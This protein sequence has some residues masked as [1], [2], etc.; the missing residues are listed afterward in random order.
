MRHHQQPDIYESGKCC[1]AWALLHFLIACLLAASLFQCRQ[2]DQAEAGA[3]PIPNDWFYRQRA[4]PSGQI[5]QAKYVKAM[6]QQQA[7][8]AAFAMRGLSSQ[9]VFRGPTNI[10][11]RIADLAIHPANPNT[12]FVGAASGG[13]FRSYDRGNTF[14]PIFD[15]ALSLSIGDIEIAPSNPAVIYAGTGEANAGGGS[16]A[17]EGV[18]I[19]KS[20]NG[21]NTWQHSGLENSGSIGRIAIHPANPNR[22]YAAA[23]GRL[24]GNNAERGVYRSSNGGQ[25]WEQVLFLNDSTGAID[26]A[27]HPNRPDTLYAAMW[28]RL[29]RP[30]YYYYGGYSSGIYRSY[31]GGD[32]WEKLANG[33]PQG[34]AGRI[35]LALSPANPQVIY[36]QYITPI[37]HIMGVYR[38]NDGGNSW[39]STGTSGITGPNFMWWFGR[40]FPHPHDPETVYFP[41]I[42]LFR[43][44]NGGQNWVGV[45]SGVHVDQHDLY[46]DPNNPDYLVLANDGGLYISENSAQSWEH[47]KGLPLIQ[48]YTCEVDYS[49][50]QRRYGG[51]Q[52]NGTIRTTTG[53]TND[54]R[55]ILPGDGFYCLVDPTDNNFV[56][57]ESQYGI[58][59]RSINGG[60]SFQFALAG[61]PSTDRRNWNTPFVFNP[62]NPRSLYYGTFRL[63]KS[64]NRALSWSAISDNLTGPGEPG[65]L[66]YGTITSIS[67]SAVDTNLIYVATDNGL[68]WKT[69]DGGQ[70]WQLLSSALPRRW[71]TRV[72]AC[73]ADALT[74][75]VTF[76]GY[77]FD[78][79]LP[80]VFKTTDGGQSWLD[81]SGG[82]PE[83]PVNEIVIDPDSPANLYLANDVGVFASFNA[84]N[85]WNNIS[86][87]LPAIVV[88]DLCLHEP[89]QE[90]YAAT[91]GRSMYSLPLAQLPAPAQPLSGTVRRGDGLPIPAV[92]ASLAGQSNLP[93]TTDGNGAYSFTGLAP[94]QS[95][96]L[97]MA[98]PGDHLSGISTFD[99]LLINRHILGVEPFD[100]PY[101]RIAAD[102]NN[103]HSITTLDMI[104]LRRLILG[105]DIALAA[106]PSWRFVP[107]SYA[108]PNPANPW[109]A[110]FPESLPIPSMPASGLNNQ[111]FIGI[112]MGDVNWDG[113]F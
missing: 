24:F 15:D 81:I 85:T 113:S 76:S 72:A 98:R 54:W 71:A 64:D 112:K 67:V 87:G 68:V 27:M 92:Q 12:I 79:Y 69:P 7:A 99:L 47:K 16:L 44:T 88:S 34:E 4:Y 63:Y 105:I 102:V 93:I 96:T 51:T 89:S 6:R 104:I 62:L 43:T 3:E 19:Y 97:G 30:E 108:F 94:Q 95:Y 50:P 48:F 31:D 83:V 10:V 90:L 49:D 18:G 75:Y 100:S 61:V 111:D 65:N 23:M 39:F 80:H 52:D 25:S 22:V 82:L 37:G 78:D 107:A 28:E 20:I 40:L 86:Q 33:L 59:R 110:P 66:A 70:D 8:A 106:V 35:G 53:N 41:S 103:S 109:S 36:A 45:G 1:P 46:I 13:I 77:R 29:R 56:Y 11:G 26:L 17:Y 2:A 21:G 55:G 5:D 101:K 14:T 60:T 73:P 42:N 38:S 74:A 84:G 57:G 9:W 32:T 58:L 91:Y